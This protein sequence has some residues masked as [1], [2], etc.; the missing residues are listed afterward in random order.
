MTER[1]CIGCRALE[2][3]AHMVRVTLGD[4]GGLVLSLGGF[5]P[6]RG[7]WLHARSE[8]LVRAAPALPRA[9]KARA[10]SS[11]RELAALLRA[12]ADR[13]ALALLVAV[14]RAGRAELGEPTE[15]SSAALPS[16]TGLVVIATDAGADAPAWAAPLVAS[17]RAVCFSTRARLGA[18]WIAVREDGAARELGRIIGLTT[19]EDPK[20]ARER[21]RPSVSSEVG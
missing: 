15:E 21:A 10:L 16:G 18:A 3:P 11:P 7:A 6:G 13:A 20:A 5:T 8:C 14:R 2:H 9:L 17:G 19:L 4:D 1:T 12:A